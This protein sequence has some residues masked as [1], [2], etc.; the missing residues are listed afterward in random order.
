M[1]RRSFH[2]KVLY[3][4]C[5]LT[6]L[7][8]ALLALYA[9]QN[10]G[11]V[12]KHLRDSAIAALDAQAGEMLE[13]RAIMVAREVAD[14]LRDIEDDLH[15]LAGL[16]PAVETYL[17][18]ARSHDRP[19]W[20]QAGGNAAPHEE[21]PV[22]PL[23]SEIAFVDAAG[24]ERIRVV[25][26]APSEELRD[27]SVPANTSYRSETY[28]LEASELAD[29]EIYVSHVTGWH[30]NKQEQLQGAASPE[31]AIE[32]VKYRGVVRFAR[33]VRDVRGELVGLLVLSLDHRHLM[34]FTQHITPT[35]ERFVVFPSYQS[36]NYAFMF[37]DE[38]WI[39]T[40]PK[41]WDLRGLDRQGRLVPPYTEHSSAAA[42][43]LGRIPYNLAAAGFIHP[44]YPVV[45]RAVLDGRSG[46]VDVTNVGGS[47]KI[48]AYAPI[49]YDTGPYARSGVFGGITI[50]AEVRQFHSVTDAA[51][52]RIDRLYS[53]FVS[54]TWM[55][56]GLTVVLMLLAAYRLSL[57]V[58]HP[59]STLVAG[60]RQLARGKLA[61]CIEI[62]GPDE[63]AELAAAFNSMTKQLYDRRE[64]L[65]RTLAELRR[66]RHQIGQ[67]RDFKQTIVE[68]VDAGILTLDENR[69]VT[70]SNGPACQL[71]GIDGTGQ[72]PPVCDL[73]A[74]W[75]QLVAAIRR[76]DEQDRWSEYVTVERAGRTQTFRL[77][78]HRLSSGRYGGSILTVEDLTERVNMRQQMARIE[79][80]ASLGRLSAGIAH[81][82]R[83]PLTGISLLLDELHDRLLA[84]PADRALIQRALQEIERL[85]GLVGELLNFAAPSTA[86]LVQGDVAAILRDILF[87]MGKQVQNSGVELRQSIPAELPHPRIDAPRLKQALLNLLTNA[88]DA[89]PAGGVLT[90]AAAREADRVRITVADSGEGIP[91]DRLPLIFEPFYTTKGEGTGLGL[92]I[93]H[94]IIAS[95][96][97]R[98]EVDSRVGA[99][100]RF[101]ILLPDP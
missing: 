99:G 12:Q 79:R 57:A 81:E 4:F 16:P 53:S 98:I 84:S 71:L 69:R 85:E 23:Y 9:A 17:A 72:S 41:F 34:E 61:P 63:L 20:L 46:V 67:E 82:V 50:G 77:A 89:M 6:L 22:T 30:V 44:N 15:F 54:G 21:R 68:N 73:L 78:M 26:G 5:G 75:P 80:L 36:G 60:T 87:L 28:F 96:G 92:S 65:L 86:Q 2:R 33:P 101:D 95:H 1:S 29:G 56:I 62:D 74:G 35:R 7:P 3:A 18:F 83:N 13:L 51:S 11:Q 90:V 31:E 25:D 24:R 91:A 70:S 42:I 10:L 55:L 100:T 40:H 64:R 59:L 14:F 48:M 38:G 19:L 32:G 37:D 47:R 88:L 27:V 52:A 66:S 39:I 76:H 43:A 58:T 8:M 45:H 49:F 97:G 94:T 93:T